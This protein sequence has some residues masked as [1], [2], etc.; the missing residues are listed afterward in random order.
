MFSAAAAPF[1]L[2]TQ[3]SIRTLA[4]RVSHAAALLLQSDWSQDKI[5]S[6]SSFGSADVFQR[7]FRRQQPGMTP[8]GYRARRQQ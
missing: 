5:A 3:F 8:D 1:L 4:L 7:A 2:H 6:P